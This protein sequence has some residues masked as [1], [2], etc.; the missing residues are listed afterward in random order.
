MHTPELQH[1][2][3]SKLLLAP[4]EDLTQESLTLAAFWFIGE[5]SS[6]RCTRGRLQVVCMGISFLH[7]VLMVCFTGN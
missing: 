6:A 1:Y 2:T 3:G 5:P 4:K 7:L